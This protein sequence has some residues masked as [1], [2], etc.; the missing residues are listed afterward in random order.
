VGDTEN[1]AAYEQQPDNCVQPWL[2]SWRMGIDKGNCV[3]RAA[4]ADGTQ[5]ASTQTKHSDLDVVGLATIPWV[6]RAA[7]PAGRGGGSCQSLGKVCVCGTETRF[8]GRPS[9]YPENLEGRD[10]R[11]SEAQWCRLRLTSTGE[12]EGGRGGTRWRRLARE[13][14]RGQAGDATIRWTGLSSAV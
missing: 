9:G 14:G 13:G 2:E 8:V 12:R 3:M 11:V 10:Y 6:L 5:R 1:G 4:A 7:G